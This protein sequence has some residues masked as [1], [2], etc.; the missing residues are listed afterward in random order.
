MTNYVFD[1]V[2]FT[3]DSKF[4]AN[5]FE[6]MGNS[7]IS[8]YQ[9]FVG[10]M[11]ASK[12]ALNDSYSAHYAVSYLFTSNHLNWINCDRF[13]PNVGDRMNFMS[14]FFGKYNCRSHNRAGQ[15]TPPEAA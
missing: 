15:T 11:E 3:E 7:K 9:D 13:D 14:V 5:N 8:I 1:R 12:K 6:K 10:E 2:A 4:F